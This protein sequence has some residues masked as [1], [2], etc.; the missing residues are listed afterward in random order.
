MLGDILK[1]ARK[2]KGFTQ[3][4][5][6]TLV[7]T[8]I[9]NIQRYES[10]KVKPRKDKLKKIAKVLDLNI[11]KL[12][13]LNS[14]ISNKEVNELD[15]LYFNDNYNYLEELKPILDNFEDL[16]KEIDKIND[17]Q[18]RKSIVEIINNHLDYLKEI[19]NQ[20]IEINQLESK[21]SK[22]KISIESLRLL[23][24]KCLN[25]EEKTKT[26]RM[27]RNEQLIDNLKNI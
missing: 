26:I 23:L 15:Y 10:N 5:L 1:K 7:E 17:P 24:E 12:I 19:L 6:A 13:D 18:I 21:I 22:V 9:R 16:L 11:N 25:L 27:I 3:K 14:E 8:D 20:V 4:E 2:N